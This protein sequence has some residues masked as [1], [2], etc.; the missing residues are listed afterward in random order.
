M[1]GVGDRAAQNVKLWPWAS[2]QAPRVGAS[3]I[4]SPNPQ[5]YCSQKGAWDGNPTLSWT[6]AQVH[7]L[8][9]QDAYDISQL[10]HPAELAALSA[11]LGRPLL[12]RDTP[13]SW[14]RPPPSRVLPTSPADMA[15]FINDVGPPGVERAGGTHTPHTS[16][17]MFP[18]HAQ[19]QGVGSLLGTLAEL[20]GSS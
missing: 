16:I 12:R 1:G 6:Q 15:D 10:R 7:A 5:T 14:V 9:P 4:L 3:Q 2:T 19:P 13:F 17:S 20:P 8:C 18:V 11:P